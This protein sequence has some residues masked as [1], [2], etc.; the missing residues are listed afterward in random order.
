MATQN[1][2][3]NS[4]NQEQLRFYLS[5][6]NSFVGHAFVEALRNDHINDVNPHFI[7]GSKCENDSTEVPRGVFR[8][9]D[10]SKISFLAKVLLD[11][12]VIVY[13][14][15]TCDLEEAEFAIKTL[16]MGEYEENK[17][18]ICISNVMTWSNTQPKEKKEGQEDEEEEG[19]EE[20]QDSEQDQEQEQVDGDE[21]GLLQKK[22][23]AKFTEN[24]YTMRK[25]LPKYEILKQIETLCLSAG[26]QK[27]N[28][29]T[30]VLCSGILYGDGEDVLY[31]HF[32]QAWLQ[33]PAELTIY[34]EGKN[35]IPMI[36]VRDLAE[37]VKKI[38]ERPPN[39]QYIFAVDHNS[40]PTQK[41]I[42]QAISSGVGSGKTKTI[43]LAEGAM[44]NENFD[45]FN[46]DL[47]IRPTKAFAQFEAESEEAGDDEEEENADAPPKFKFNWHC[48]EGITK[49]ILKVCQEFNQFRG[50]KPNRF[51]LQGPVA[52]G[53]TFY[54]DQLAKHYNI[55]HIKIKDVVDMY[56]KTPGEEGDTIREEYEN[57]KTE[58]VEAARTE[59]EKAQ[60]KK[61][62]PAK[63]EPVE[64][65][66][67]N[68][69]IVRLPDEMLI[70]AYKQR[71]VMTDCRNRGF[72]ID[73][74]PKTF[75]QAKAIFMKP[76]P[77][78]ED[79]DDQAEDWPQIVD[80]EIIPDSVIFLEASN[81]Y[82]LNFVKENLKE[83]QVQGTH[84][85][86]EGMNTRL[87]QYRQN[88][89]AQDGEFIL[90]DFFKENGVEVLEINLENSK[91]NVMDEM[92]SFIER[93]GEFSNYMVQEQQEEEKR[94]EDLKN[95]NKNQEEEES[96]QAELR[97]QN[98]EEARE[99]QDAEFKIKME[100]LKNQ[101]RDIL[102]KRSQP[103]R[104]YLAD[105]VVPFLTEGLIE[106]C[107]NP[108]DD[109]VDT[110]AE[111]L[112]KRSLEVQFP[113]PGEY[114]AE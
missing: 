61:K 94:K 63:G 36:H 93:N 55:P 47:R 43:S 5:S 17:I 98:E 23:Y 52:S 28:L 92:R 22:Q 32:R 34:G 106:I 42:I 102:D 33:D 20:E 60:K 21:D 113:D 16:K 66:N 76:K 26:N 74:Y 75:N 77:A 54:S 50:L 112:F 15:N 114:K 62:K 84:Y 27:S 44:E 39:Q 45:I 12:D 8:C 72:I 1:D 87:Q 78:G 10:T 86:E 25:A 67:E 41:K 18:L 104:Q 111:Y 48:K 105:N 14:L 40:K 9:I 11:C 99:I 7:V 100:N 95:Q 46:L 107:K 65:F 88:N 80:T 35:R 85:T 49:N 58:Q 24:D 109:P 51:F 69:V 59:W 73:G 101:E 53:K 19:Q 83:E 6:V 4:K 96:K 71:L 70:K 79:E 108:S 57:L 31:N 38:V 103:L 30:F 90:S 81:E 56:L 64:E 3:K 89:N 110:L 82:L 2:K 97:D 68:S 91:Q 37:F 13:D 29:K